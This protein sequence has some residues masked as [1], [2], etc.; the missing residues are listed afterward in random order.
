MRRNNYPTAVT[1]IENAICAVMDEY[2]NVYVR[3]MYHQGIE[4]HIDYVLSDE[5]YY[6]DKEF[7]AELKEEERGMKDF[8]QYDMDKLNSAY[9]ELRVA[10]INTSEYYGLDG[11]IYEFDDENL[12]TIYE[13]IVT[14][15]D[16]EDFLKNSEYW[17]MK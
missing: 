7:Y 5:E 8:C 6:A 14:D 11:A 1:T 9:Q 4:F 10:Y 13:R 15:A 16:I 3:F 12:D 2:K 17:T